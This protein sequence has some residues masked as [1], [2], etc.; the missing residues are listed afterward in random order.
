[1]TIFEYIKQKATKV[2]LKIV[3]NIDGTNNKKSGFVKWLG[4]VK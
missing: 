4:G 1:M 3:Y 2:G